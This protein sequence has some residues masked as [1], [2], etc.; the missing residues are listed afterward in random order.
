MRHTPCVRG[1][2]SYSQRGLHLLIFSRPRQRADKFGAS[3]VD[4]PPNRLPH[5]EITC[6][7]QVQLGCLAPLGNLTV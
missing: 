6:T 1:V 2:S 4:R 7:V 3:P 5:R